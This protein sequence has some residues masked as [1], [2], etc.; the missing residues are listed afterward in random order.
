MRDPRR[1]TEDAAWRRLGPS[2]ASTQGHHAYGE[3]DDGGADRQLRRCSWTWRRQSVSSATRKRRA[4]TEWPRS[5]RCASMSPRIWAAERPGN[6]AVDGRTGSGW[7]LTSPP[8]SAAV[9]VRPRASPWCASPPRSPARA[10]AARRPGRLG[11]RRDRRPPRSSRKSAASMKYPGH[12][13]SSK[14]S[15]LISPGES[16]HDQDQ[17]QEGEGAGGDAHR[18]ATQEACRLFR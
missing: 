14:K 7:A 13:L 15:S 2:A 18:G 9:P 10:P 3:A 8:L 16:V 1:T 17:R 6:P 4:S 5:R 12:T 11:R